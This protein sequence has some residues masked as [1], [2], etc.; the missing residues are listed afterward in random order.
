[1]I[2]LYKEPFY[3]WENGHG[4]AAEQ[5]IEEHRFQSQTACF[6]ILGHRLL[7]CAFA[8]GSPNLSYN[9]VCHP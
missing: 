6:R 7:V 9:S 4:E 8:H 2:K 1:M 3:L 5:D